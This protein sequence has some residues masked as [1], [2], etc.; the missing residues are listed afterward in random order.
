[1]HIPTFKYALPMGFPKQT[2]RSSKEYDSNCG[3]LTST[4]RPTGPQTIPDNDVT[5]K[6]R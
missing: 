2:V 5:I 3:P 1:M 6:G 4:A